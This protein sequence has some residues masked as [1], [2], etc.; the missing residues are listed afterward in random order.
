[1]L[2]LT[3]NRH[4]TFLRLFFVGSFYLAKCLSIHLNLQVGL[5]HHYIFDLKA[6]SQCTNRSRQ[7]TA[8]TFVWLCLISVLP[9]S[10]SVAIGQYFFHQ[11]NMKSHFVM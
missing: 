7:M 1:M 2:N 11:R 10:A 9:L 8:D 6:N 4:N 5:N 3:Y